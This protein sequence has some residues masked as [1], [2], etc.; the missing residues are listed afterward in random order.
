MKNESPIIV[1][2]M[3]FVAASENELSLNDKQLSQLDFDARHDFVLDDDFG[4]IVA[5]LEFSNTRCYSDRQRGVRRHVSVALVDATERVPVAE[6]SVKVAMSA[7][8]PHRTGYV[9]FGMAEAE[10]R[11]GHTYRLMVRD[12]ISGILLEESVIHIFST[13]ELEHPCLWYE[14]TGGGIRPDWEPFSI[15]R[16]VKVESGKELYVRFN[17]THNFGVKLPAILPELE[18]R[19]YN[20][21]GAVHPVRFIEP[22][23]LDPQTGSLYVEMPF[24]SSSIYRGPYYAEL[25]C[26]QYPIAGFVF[27]TRGPEVKGECYGAN[28]VPFDDYSKEAAEER[29]RRFAESEEDAEKDLETE[30]FDEFLDRFI[31]S[32][33]AALAKELADVETVCEQGEAEE[34]K[35]EA[36]RADSKEHCSIVDSLS[37]LT[38]LSSVKNKL[39]KYEKLVAFN[40]MRAENGL[41]VGNMPLH[42]MFLGS[43]G[44]GKTTVAQRV[45]V[46]LRRAGVLSKGHV[47]IRERATLLGQNYSSE[48]ENTLKA[49]EEAQGGILLID[50]AYQLF[51]PNDPRDPGKF[52]IESLLTALADESRRD[53]MLILAGYPDRMRRMFEMN[54]GL[55]SRI[56]DSNIYE[57]EDFTEPELMEI[58][59]RYFERN[60]YTLSPDARDALAQRLSADYRQRDASFGNARHVVNMILTDIVPAMAERVI[61]SGVIDKTRLTEI[62]ASDIPSPQSF[63]DTSSRRRVGF[64]A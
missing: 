4:G 46:M 13:D 45:G 50:E 18:V 56:P 53:W 58:A 42:A 63:R 33:Q 25:L 57:F 20:P 31:R 32:E 38:G 34:L 47:V 36:P 59:E 61:E 2:A 30:D 40:K 35:T 5:K 62:Q 15:Y 41:P 1:E 60:G 24:F 21:E 10:F 26:M 43:P 51:Q 27:S 55:K 29:F 12:D 3:M 11:H 44:T 52:V 22:K 7:K 14:V 8:Q 64:R 17:L 9:T 23:F 37:M 28:I 6:K 16:S 54:P 49:I 19:L 39:G 48:S